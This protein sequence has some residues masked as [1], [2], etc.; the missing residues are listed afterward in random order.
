MTYDFHGS[1]DTQV[2]HHSPIYGRS[3]G[4]N[5]LAGFDMV[6]DIDAGSMD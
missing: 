2:A 5:S 4:A 6:R 3:R 1:W